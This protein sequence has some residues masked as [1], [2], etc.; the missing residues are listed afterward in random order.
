MKAVLA[1][2]LLSGVLV[3]AF[4]TSLVSAVSF[5]V[6]YTDPASDVVEFWTSNM[7]PVLTDGNL[8]LS[9]F[10][11]SVNMLHLTSANASAD[12]VLTMQVKGTIA[13]LDNT[14]YQIRLYTRQ[15]NA[16]H[17]AVTHV[18][19]TTLLA[20]NATG[21]VPIDLSGST[22]IVQD[23]LSVRVA[24]SGLGIITAWEIDATATETGAVYTYMD[25]GWRIPGNPGSAPQLPGAQFILPNTAWIALVPVV[26]AIVVVIV[27]VL[28]DRAER[29]SKKSSKAKEQVASFHRRGKP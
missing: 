21:F 5:D 14:S 26:I 1:G 19:R 17:F 6:S 10:P 8:T 18:N 25:Y 12:V 13:N 24:K 3:L 20:S 27:I 11:D 15:D 16:T 29:S 2:V 23:T 28:K 7:T 22:T 9:P 4:G